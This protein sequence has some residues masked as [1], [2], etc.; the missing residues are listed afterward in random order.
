MSIDNCRSQVITAGRGRRSG[1]QSDR[2]EMKVAFCHMGPVINYG[3]GGGY[4][5]VVGK[6]SFTPTKRGADKVLAILNG[7]HKKFWGSFN[8]G[9]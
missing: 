9:A 7:R 2:D 3:E 1:R 5:T 8:T 6:R 4:K